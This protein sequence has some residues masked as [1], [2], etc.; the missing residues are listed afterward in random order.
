MGVGT[1]KRDGLAAD[2]R[3]G[4]DEAGVVGREEEIRAPFTL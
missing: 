4:E 3:A 2:V 1:N